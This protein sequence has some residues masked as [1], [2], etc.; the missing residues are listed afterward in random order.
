MTIWFRFAVVLSVVA[1]A[2]VGHRMRVNAVEER[3][4]ELVALHEEREKAQRELARA[5]QRLRRLTRRL[6][7]AKEDERRHIARELHDEMGPTLTAVII[8]LQL[9]LESPDKG[10]AADRVADT[11]DLVDRLIDRVRDLS[12]DLRPPLLDELGLLPALK[13]YLESQANRTGIEIKVID[14]GP[15]KA[16]PA[17]IEIAAFRVVQEAVTNVIRH[18]SASQAIVTVTRENGELLLRVKDDG[19]GFDVRATLDGASAKTLG[20]L[21]MQ[22]RVG[23]LGGEVEIDSAPGRGTEVRARVPVEVAA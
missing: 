20:L 12:L 17:E 19:R 22:E 3:N 13:G 9:L 21:G 8:N 4:R 11:I 16:L 7:A 18:A 23:I 5:Y 14:D 15:T 1:L 2:I 6:E 10:D